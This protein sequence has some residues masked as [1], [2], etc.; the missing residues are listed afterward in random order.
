MKFLTD[1]IK[2]KNDLLSDHGINIRKCIKLA[3]KYYIEVE[4]DVK[5]KYEGKAKDYPRY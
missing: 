2:C 5:K 3:E 1:F 4:Y